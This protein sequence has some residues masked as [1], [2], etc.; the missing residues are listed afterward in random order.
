M[1]HFWQHYLDPTLRSNFLLVVT[2]AVGGYIVWRVYRNQKDDEKR[3]AANI[4]LL[5]IERAEEELKK[6]SVDRVFTGEDEDDVMLMKTSSWDEY[7][8]FFVQDF[9]GHHDELAK[10]SDFYALC[11]KYDDAVAGQNDMIDTN[12]KEMIQNYQGILAKST[13]EYLEALKDTKD[14]KTKAELKQQ[15]LA[16]RKLF[17][18]AYTGRVSRDAPISHYTPVRF[19]NNAK[20]ALS[21]IDRNLSTSSAGQRLKKIAAPKIG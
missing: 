18:D 12:T 2:T 11:E 15:Y 19:A 9:F 1:L 20:R 5:E 8:H 10:I 16:G 3:S 13:E 4:V 14:E 17:D 7:K 21:T 6:I